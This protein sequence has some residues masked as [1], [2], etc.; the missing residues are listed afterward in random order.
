MGGVPGVVGGLGIDDGVA[1][2]AFGARGLGHGTKVGSPLS[3][4]RCLKRRVGC[5]NAAPDPLQDGRGCG[6]GQ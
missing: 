5:L 6:S 2:G 1:D 3:V 4:R